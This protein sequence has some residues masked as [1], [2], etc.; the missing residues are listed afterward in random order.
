MPKYKIEVTEVQEPRLI[1]GGTHPDNPPSLTWTVEFDPCN[2]IMKLLK[3]KRSHKK[4][5]Q[6]GKLTNC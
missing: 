5:A 6:Q 1:V 2:D 4:K 3:S